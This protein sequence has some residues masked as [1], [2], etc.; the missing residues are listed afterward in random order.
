MCLVKQ[1]KTIN[2]IS[3]DSEK[4]KQNKNLLICSLAYLL[5]AM[6]IISTCLGRISYVTQA[7]HVVDTV[8]LLDDRDII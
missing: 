2:G 7:F 6:Y 1:T 3:T 5:L 8:Q 4:K